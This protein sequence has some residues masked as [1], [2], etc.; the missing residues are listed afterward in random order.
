MRIAFIVGSFP[1]LSET[2][3]LN[4]ITGLIEMGH[5]IDIYS[6]FKPNQEKIH[7]DVAKYNLLDRTYYFRP[8]PANKLVRLLEALYLIIYNFYR[9]Y[10]YIF[11]RKYFK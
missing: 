5:E 8:V 6:R 1:A 9:N 2:F 3:I 4:Q 10:Y 7:P 11:N